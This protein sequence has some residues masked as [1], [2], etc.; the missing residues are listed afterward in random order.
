VAVPLVRRFDPRLTL[1][2]EVVNQPEALVALDA[3][4]A[5]ELAQW[6]TCGAAIK[7]IGEAV[8]SELTGTLITAGSD[9]RTLPKLWSCAPGLGAIDVHATAGLQLP[10]RTELANALAISAA[11]A[12]AI[13][14]IGG[15][16]AGEATS[17]HHSDYIAIFGL[18][19]D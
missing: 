6:Q 14:L 9:W 16:L 4:A 17:S 18:R 8:R 11:Q 3:S 7:T 13:P 12:D 15:C 1:A 2:V 19:F 5:E 10:S